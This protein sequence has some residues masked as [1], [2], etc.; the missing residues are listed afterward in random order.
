MDEL[1][2]RVARVIFLSMMPN[3]MVPNDWDSGAILGDGNS[4]RHQIEMAA[5]LAVI[6]L[7]R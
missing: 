6:E 4:F 1:E 7:C 2:V 5:K 3:N